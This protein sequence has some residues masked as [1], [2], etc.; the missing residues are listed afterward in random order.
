LNTLHELELLVPYQLSVS[1]IVS[2]KSDPLGST[3][4][5]SVKFNLLLSRSGM[6][7][8]VGGMSLMFYRGA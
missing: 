7:D 1:G 3:G 4:L 8:L 5:S 6:N 2:V